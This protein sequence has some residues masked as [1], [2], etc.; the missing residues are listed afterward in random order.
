M[1]SVERAI[2]PLLSELNG[3]KVFAKATVVGCAS[4]TYWDVPEESQADFLRLRILDE[5]D[6]G[7]N[8]AQITLKASDKGG[9]VNRVEVDLGVSDHVQANKLL[10]YL[11]GDPLGQVTKRYTVYFLED[12][13]T[14]ISVYKV[15]KDKRIFVEVEATTLKRVKE[16]T[17]TL[18]EKGG[19]KVER[20]PQSLFDMF[21]QK[22][23]MTP[24]PVQ[25]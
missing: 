4:D 3:G 12:V 1:A 13:H 25:F 24:E 16:M 2:Y 21:V 10:T 5:P 22:K 23:I 19:L 18:V 15:M 9:N 8:P 20:I 14:T 17:K 7:G 11:L 6:E